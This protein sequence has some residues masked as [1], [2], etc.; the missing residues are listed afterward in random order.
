MYLVVPSVIEINPLNN[1]KMEYRL[2]SNLKSYTINKHYLKWFITHNV[3]D[4]SQRIT[5]ENDYYTIKNEQ[6]ISKIYLYTE[7]E[8]TPPIFAALS[9]NYRDR[10]RFVTVVG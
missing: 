2:V 10:I 1:K 8:Q 4:Y 9:A 5:S 3:P 7:K 6:G